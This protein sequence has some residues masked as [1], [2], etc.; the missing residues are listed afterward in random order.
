MSSTVAVIVNFNSGPLLGPALDRLASQRVEA[1]VVI[2]N[3]SHD[4]SWQ[5]AL[6]RDRVRLHRLEANRGF[7][8]AVNYALA[9][10]REPY[11]FLLNADVEMAD[12]Y[13]AY[14]ADALDAAPRVAGAT[15]T[16]TLP[17]GLIDSTGITFTRARCAFDRGRGATA[18]PAEPEEPFAVSGAAC[19]LRRDAVAQVGGMWEELFVYW[20]DTEVAWRMR[21]AGWRFAHVPAARAVHARGSDSA[22]A[23]FIE[24][25]EFGG[26]LAAIARNEGWRG[27]VNPEALLAT[28]VS[29]ARLAVRHRA[30]LRT[31]RPWDRVRTGLAARQ[32][33]ELPQDR[34]KF[35]PHP[36]RAWLTAQFTGR[37]RGLG[38]LPASP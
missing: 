32:S 1:T 20:E 23:T 8:A 11:V 22:D 30:A 17:S 31:S 19:L 14:L 10:T 5:D 24:A 29:G 6:G 7:A 37:R 12:G 28:L 25:A 2:D 33:D 15:G 3:A 36:W 38:A 26:R 9:A 13:V 18:A 4:L 27:L 21:R 16:L 35:A 34:P